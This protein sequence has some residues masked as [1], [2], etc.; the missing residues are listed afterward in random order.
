MREKTKEKLIAS[1]REDLIAV[2]E[3]ITSGRAGVNK[4]GKIVDRQIETNAVPIKENK[5]F[6]TPKPV[7][8]I[9]G[10]KRRQPSLFKRLCAYTDKYEIIFQLW[11]MDKNSIDISKDSVT[12]Y[13]IYDRKTPEDAMRD[14]LKY[15]D[16]ITKHSG[17]LGSPL[18]SNI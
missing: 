3:L 12:L 5:L 15:L 13:N 1:G 11:G 4:D 16:R 17:V 2:Y 18:K 10:Q 14:A 6:N 7:K 8:I 9:A